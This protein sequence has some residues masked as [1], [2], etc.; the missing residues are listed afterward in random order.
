MCFV[1]CP[2]HK[3]IVIVPEQLAG[4]SF[5]VGR[6]VFCEFSACR[7]LTRFLIHHR[8]LHTPA[9]THTHTHTQH[10][11]SFYNHRC[12]AV[13]LCLWMIRRNRLAINGICQSAWVTTGYVEASI[14]STWCYVSKKSR[15]PNQLPETCEPAS[16]SPSLVLSSRMTI[17]VQPSSQALVT[18]TCP[19]RY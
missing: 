10:I 8:I 11:S 13:F 1:W 19:L 15:Y 17:S 5:L 16:L 3:A 2:E 4:Y 9:H 18:R 14:T 12:A 6:R 7:M